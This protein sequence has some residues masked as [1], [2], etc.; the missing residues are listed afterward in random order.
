MT[1][2]NKFIGKMIFLFVGVLALTACSPEDGKDGL[3]GAQGPQGP[4]GNA[5]VTLYEFEGTY[6]FANTSQFQFTCDSTVEEA[7]NSLWQGFIVLA[8]DERLSFSVPGYGT[9]SSTFYRLYV[10]I[11]FGRAD[12][13]IGRSTGP[14]ETYNKVRIFRILANNTGAVNKT[15]SDIKLYNGYTEEEVRAMSYEEFV[16]A[17]ELSVE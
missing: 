12:I 4:M 15:M 3:D 13:W 8:S 16:N 17:F 11:Y 2:T 10:D 7:E 6:N 1:T 5:N 9:G 14:G